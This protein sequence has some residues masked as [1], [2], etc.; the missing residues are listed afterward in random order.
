MKDI[1]TAA[2]VYI[3]IKTGRG[4]GLDQNI[5]AQVHQVKE[6]LTPLSEF[7]HPSVCFSNLLQ[8]IQIITLYFLSR[9]S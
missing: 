3:R 7:T 4:G 2:G 8:V 1:R 5:K 6:E 9:L